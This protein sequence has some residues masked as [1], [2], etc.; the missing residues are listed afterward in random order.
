MQSKEAMHRVCIREQEKQ[1]RNG[2]D[3]DGWRRKL[4]EMT[5]SPL[6]NEQGNCPRK[7]K[8]GRTIAVL[9]FP[10]LRLRVEALDFTGSTSGPRLVETK[11]HHDPK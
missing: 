2:G 7:P 6:F 9:A 1:I 4:E 11:E 10:A 8:R 3:V 5:R